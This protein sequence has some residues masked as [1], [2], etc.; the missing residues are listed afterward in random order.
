MIYYKITINGGGEGYIV[1]E[2]SL[3]D[4]IKAEVEGQ[5][6]LSAGDSVT[7]TA[8]EM[9]EDEYEALDEFSGW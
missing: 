8:V 6:G 3:L 2:D 5:D 1:R 9:T 4:A 7:V